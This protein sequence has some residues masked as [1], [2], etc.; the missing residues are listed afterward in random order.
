MGRTWVPEEEPPGGGPGLGVT[1]CGRAGCRVTDKGFCRLSTDCHPKLLLP[2]G[3][4]W[5][6][7]FIGRAPRAG[8]LP[9]SSQ[10]GRVSAH[11]GLGSLPGGPPLG[12]ADEE[13][14]ARG[15]WQ[16]L[17]SALG[18]AALSRRGTCC[19][20]EAPGWFGV[21]VVGGVSQA[22]GR[23]DPSLNHGCAGSSWVAGEG[24]LPPPLSPAS[25]VSSSPGSWPSPE[26]VWGPSLTCRG[27]D[28]RLAPSAARSL[29]LGLAF[30]C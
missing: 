29:S 22:S 2:V 6:V 26:N 21:C 9:A 10:P 12:F 8:G 15:C 18:F 24:L 11:G 14:E 23:G 30:S 7:S 16:G 28:S 27:V 13:T 3:T 19:L 1:V 17:G 4:G 20:E 25:V 5:G